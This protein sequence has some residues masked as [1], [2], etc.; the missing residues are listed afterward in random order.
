MILTEAIILAALKVADKMLDLTII[1]IQDQPK[2]E[3]E[4][5]W[6]R[7]FQFWEPLWKAIGLDKVSGK[8]EKTD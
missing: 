7:W 2:D 4:K 8:I 3:R 6:A 5:A 1:T